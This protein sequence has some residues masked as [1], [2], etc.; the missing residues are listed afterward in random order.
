MIFTLF[1]SSCKKNNDN[2]KINENIT[3]VITKIPTPTY[4]IE[5]HNEEPES[6]YEGMKRSYLMG[7]WIPEEEADKRPL[8]IMFNNIGIASPQ[9]GIGDADI[10]Y[11][12]LVEAGITRLM[13]IFGRVS[14][15]SLAARRLGSIRSSRHYFASFASEYDAIYVNFGGTS[16]SDKKI[17]KLGLDNISGLGGYGVDSFYRDNTIK[18]P[19]NAFTSLDGINKAIKKGNMRTELKEDYTAHF[20]F[21]EEDTSLLSNDTAKKITVSF[22]SGMQPYFLYNEE[23]KNYTRYQFDKIHVDYNT[24]D[25]LRFKNII[26]QFVKQWDIDKN[27]YQTMEL[28]DTQ[29]EGYY[30]TNGNIVP[31]TWK[32]NE[33][34]Y[35]MKFYDIEGNELK[36][37]AGKTYIAVYPSHRSKKLIIE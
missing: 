21:Y 10:L 6:T 29:G 20:E 25:E 19:H 15:D 27:G 11:E 33:S 4:F 14:S 5:N 36:I 16:Y 23:E 28:E 7:E 2:N 18:A 37:N 24:G 12:A 34:I 32:K 26:I 3:P 9:S 1:F 30:I 17:K 35:F 31:I 22:S 8:A 13:G